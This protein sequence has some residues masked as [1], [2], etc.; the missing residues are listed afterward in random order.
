MRAIVCQGWSGIDGLKL[1]QLPEPE[2]K[3]ESESAP[4]PP[5]SSASRT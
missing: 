4:A 1:G 3:P 5:L 2:P